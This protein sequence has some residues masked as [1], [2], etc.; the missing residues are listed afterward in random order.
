MTSGRGLP[1]RPRKPREDRAQAPVTAGSPDSPA[2]GLPGTRSDINVRGTGMKFRNLQRRRPRSRQGRREVG[3]RVDRGGGRE[4]AGREGRGYLLLIQS[5]QQNNDHGVV[6][7][8]ETGP[9]CEV[10]TDTARSPLGPS[11]WMRPKSVR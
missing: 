5:W 6:S 8:E 3:S 9:P 10:R 2:W 7:T 11:E 1:P 4:A